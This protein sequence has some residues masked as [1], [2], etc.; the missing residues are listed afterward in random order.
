MLMHRFATRS[1]AARLAVSLLLVL[2]AACGRE[3]G[4]ADTGTLETPDGSDDSAGDFAP[5]SAADGEPDAPECENDLHCDD[6][7]PCTTDTCDTDWGECNHDAVD[8]DGDGYVA[9]SAGGVGCGGDDCDDH[10]HARHPGADPECDGWDHD[11]D[12]LVD[13]DEDGD[14]FFSSEVC[15]GIGD[16]CDDHDGSINPDAVPACAAVDTNCDGLLD[17]TDPS[18][19]VDCPCTLAEYDCEDAL[20]ED[21]DL[22]VDCVD[23]DCA[24]APCCAGAPCA[25]LLECCA[26]GCCDLDLDE[27]CCGGCQTA[28]QAGFHCCDG[29]CAECCVRE[30]CD[31][32]NPCTLDLCAA[33]GCINDGTVTDLLPCP[34]GICCTGVCAECCSD[35]GCEDSN[36]CT[37][38]RCE[39]GACVLGGVEADMI[40][41]PGG[42]CCGGV[43]EAPANCCS[44]ADCGCIGEV[45]PCYS[46]VNDQDVCEDQTG[47]SWEDHSCLDLHE[48]RCDELDAMECGPES[49][50]TNCSWFVPCCGCDSGTSDPLC[51]PVASETCTA[52]GDDS[53]QCASCGCTWTGT[54]CTG[55]PDCT[56]LDPRYPWV[57][58]TCQGC[59]PRPGE[60]DCTGAHVP[61]A[62]H[63][64]EAACIL[65]QTCSW[66][67]TCID[68]ACSG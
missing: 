46:F 7:N 14:G 4:I 65:Q 33:G 63:L 21:C 19:T 2:A 36:P 20:D 68:H 24:T 29:E 58:A 62:S 40:P 49:P 39:S 60:G 23:E 6:S 25:G 51:Q 54:T 67:P 37:F 31:D 11:C 34:G 41:C 27:A 44:D 61:C 17:C 13:R 12:D 38:E 52:I 53:Y 43:C 55:Y 45:D 42:V 5:D 64:E 28:C 35:E 22:E 15:P 66:L 57:C 59:L 18:C 50:C 10:D 1:R 47:C 16:D 3:D 30:D 9:Q 8:L 56:S 32:S 26:F 48:T